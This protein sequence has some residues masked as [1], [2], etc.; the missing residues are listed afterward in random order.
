MKLHF[1]RCRESAP[2]FE[3]DPSLTALVQQL[4]VVD[5]V[6][7]PALR[8]DSAAARQSGAQMG[9]S[10]VPTPRAI[11]YVALG[12]A[13][14]VAA[15]FGLAA[16]LTRDGA[17][18]VSAAAILEKARQQAAGAAESSPSVFFQIS[19]QQTDVVGRPPSINQTRIWSDG[20]RWRIEQYAIAGEKVPQLRSV[21]V[22]DG[23]SIWAYDG[24]TGE[25]STSPSTSGAG[26]PFSVLQ[27]PG[28]SLQMLFDGRAEC[29]SPVLTGSERIAGREA[30]VIDLGRNRCLAPE[31]VHKVNGLDV[32]GRSL[33][34][35]WV[36][37]ETFAVLKSEAH[38]YPREDIIFTFELE[39]IS[40]PPSIAE[41]AFQFNAKSP[42]Y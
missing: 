15:G 34:K 38:G 2:S 23:G 11:A 28:E 22:F 7:V 40:F 13:L 27:T 21:Q 37:H 29:W 42:A 12:I 30:Y 8:F 33:R 10:L 20:T 1:P 18:S 19:K 17:T 3:S 25:V 35:I 41:E 14:F 24:A 6:P 4:R 36:D 5:S 39:D 9:R 31:H 16:S 26:R 32:I